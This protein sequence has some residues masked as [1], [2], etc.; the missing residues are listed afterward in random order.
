MVNFGL[1]RL[2]LVNPR[3]H[4]TPESYWMAR[5]GKGLL[6]G[7]EV[8][9]EFAGLQSEWQRSAACRSSRLKADRSIQ[10]ALSE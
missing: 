9:L 7:A 3:E 1:S 10:A 5:E 4:L 6:E 8:Q 2:V